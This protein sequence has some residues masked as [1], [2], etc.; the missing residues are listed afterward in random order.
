MGD[1]MV[2][3]LDSWEAGYADGRLANRAKCPSNCDALSYSS[4]YRQG[5]ACRSE[6]QQA[7]RRPRQI[8]GRLRVVRSEITA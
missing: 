5:A 2:I 3:D 8:R 1:A 7:T 6:K 4:G